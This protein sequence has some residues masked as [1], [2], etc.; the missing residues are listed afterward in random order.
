MYSSYI[1]IYIFYV[2]SIPLI[3]YRVHHE[4]IEGI[5]NRWIYRKVCG[6]KARGISCATLEKS[7]RLCAC[8]MVLYREYNITWSQCVRYPRT[9]VCIRIHAIHQR[10]CHELRLS[11][12]KKRQA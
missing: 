11:V 8:Y 2:V 10:D 5:E 1:Y 3:F 9:R 4:T 12:H 6:K 7:L